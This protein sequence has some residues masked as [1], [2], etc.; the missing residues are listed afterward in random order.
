[1]IK[2]IKTCTILILTIVSFS[3]CSNVVDLVEDNLDFEKKKKP[4]LVKT[5]TRGI[6]V[7]KLL[8]PEAEITPR[9]VAAV[10][11]TGEVG[12][13]FLDCNFSKKDKNSK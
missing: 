5:A 2:K 8:C 13:L 9:D 11:N 3:F 1:M 4:S 12:A 10:A 6:I 7:F